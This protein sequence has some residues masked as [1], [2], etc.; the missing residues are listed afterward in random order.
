M[1]IYQLATTYWD[2]TRDGG[3]PSDPKETPPF[4][5]R[6]EVPVPDVPEETPPYE[7]EPETPPVEPS[8]E[9][10]S[11]EPVV[12]EVDPL[13]EPGGEPDIPAFK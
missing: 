2:D 12:P 13:P 11:T 1:D 5:P 6:P 8:P 7:K 4:D 3:D 10:P 9:L